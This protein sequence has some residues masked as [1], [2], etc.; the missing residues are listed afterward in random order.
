[1][2]IELPTQLPPADELYATRE[3]IKALTARESELKALLISDPSSRTGNAYA[4]DIKAVVSNRCDLKELRAEHPDLVAEHTYP[5]TT[6]TV[7]LRGINDD[8]E[9]VSLRRKVTA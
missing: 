4:V 1:M 8:G 9:L 6:T 2:S 5:V 7:V 3:Q